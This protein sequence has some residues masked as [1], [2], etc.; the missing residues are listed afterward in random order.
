MR[1]S[2]RK[3]LKS[4]PA[5]GGTTMHPPRRPPT[6]ARSAFTDTPAAAPVVYTPPA[7][8]AP[9]F[10]SLDELFGGL[11]DSET[12]LTAQTNLFQLVLAIQDE[13][14][15]KQLGALRQFR[16]LAGQALRYIKESDT[17]GLDSW[18]GHIPASPTDAHAH[19]PTLLA[20]QFESATHPKPG[21]DDSKAATTKLKGVLQSTKIVNF[22]AFSLVQ[23]SKP[24][25]SGNFGLV[26]DSSG[27]IDS[28][29]VKQSVVGSSDPKQLATA[30]RAL[31]CHQY[32]KSNGLELHFVEMTITGALILNPDEEFNPGKMFA[33]LLSRLSTA[34]QSHAAFN[35]PMLSMRTQLFKQIRLT[36]LLATNPHVLIHLLNRHLTFNQDSAITAASAWSKL[37]HHGKLLLDESTIQDKIEKMGMGSGW[38]V[39]FYPGSTTRF[40]LVWTQSEASIEKSSLLAAIQ[41]S[42]KTVNPKFG[43]QITPSAASD[44]SQIKIG[45]LD[46]TSFEH[47]ATRVQRTMTR[48]AGH[49]S[50]RE[51]VAS[52][53][54]ALSRLSRR[55]KFAKP[56]AR[57]SQAGAGAGAGSGSFST[58]PKPRAT[59]RTARPSSSMAPP[60]P[61]PSAR[62]S[63]GIG[64][65]GPVGAQRAQAVASTGLFSRPNKSSSNTRGRTLGSK[66]TGSRRTVDPS[67][68]RSPPK[69]PAGA[70]LRKR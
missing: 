5:P 17:T 65:R 19:I 34:I 68:I 51:S 55:S 64:E 42:L 56:A 48:P 20:E 30:L 10:L 28:F 67:P 25:S 29:F 58:I 15:P 1:L 14:L 49:I 43:Y 60:P 37:A 4:E 16:E 45:P 62:S 13:T 39:K 47:F 52:G 26:I 2:D 21:T 69:P 44:G 8:E 3:L 41:S 33:L 46:N 24:T 63:I 31:A 36:A 11:L 70:G 35:S 22:D 53:A 7:D 54:T 18:K 66:P 12:A 9:Y 32:F 50:D 57:S 59:P 61:P 27:E 40:D 6:A 38:T 23:E